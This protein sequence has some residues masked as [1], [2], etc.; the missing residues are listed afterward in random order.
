MKKNVMATVPN[1]MKFILT[2]VL[3]ILLI[4]GLLPV[5]LTL[6]AKADDIVGEYTYAE[7]SV[8][9]VNGT[10]GT[11]QADIKRNE[12]GKYTY[13]GQEYVFKAVRNISAG[14]TM[15]VNGANITL[16]ARADDAITDNLSD[17]VN[18]ANE[19][20]I[21]TLT[22]KP[23]TWLEANTPYVYS[24]NGNSYSFT[25]DQGLGYKAPDE[26]D[27]TERTD[28]TNAKAFSQNNDGTAPAT[29]TIDTAKNTIRI[30][31]KQYTRKV[32]Y[33]ETNNFTTGNV[34]LVGAKTSAGQNNM[35]IMTLN[36]GIQYTISRDTGY[37]DSACVHNKTDETV[38]SYA[39]VNQWNAYH[40]TMDNSLVQFSGR[41]AS[42]Y[43][44][45]NG[46]AAAI[47]TN[48]FNYYFE[49]ETDDQWVNSELKTKYESN[50]FS[51]GNLLMAYDATTGTYTQDRVF[52]SINSSDPTYQSKLNF[53]KDCFGKAVVLIDHNN[54]NLWNYTTQGSTTGNKYGY[55]SNGNTLST[56]ITQLAGGNPNLYYGGSN[57]PATSED[58]TPM[59]GSRNNSSPIYL[60]EKKTVYHQDV[61][62]RTEI[63]K[64]ESSAV[65][66]TMVG[67]ALRDV[68]TTLDYEGAKVT[69]GT[70]DEQNT[71][72]N[73][74]FTVAY[75]LMDFDGLPVT[76]T[77]AL[78]GLSENGTETET[79]KCEDGIFTSNI[80]MRDA[81][82]IT[83][84]DGL[85][86]GFVLTPTIVGVTDRS[87]ADRGN[88]TF[89][90]GPNGVGTYDGDYVANGSAVTISADLGKNV[91]LDVRD[92][93]REVDIRLSY[94]AKGTTQN[95]DFTIKLY[96][97]APNGQP[98]N[99]ELKDLQG[100]TYAFE[101]GVCDKRNVTSD[102]TIH[103]GQV[104]T[105]TGV[106]NGSA[107]YADVIGG[108][109]EYDKL[110][111]VSS[112]NISLSE[113]NKLL[114]DEDKETTTNK[115]IQLQVEIQKM[116]MKITFNTKDLEQLQSDYGAGAYIE[117][118]Q[119]SDN[120]LLRKVYIADGKANGTMAKSKEVVIVIPEVESTEDLYIK[121]YPR[122]VGS[123]TGEYAKIF[124]NNDSI[125][126]VYSNGNAQTTIYSP[127]SGYTNPDSVFNNDYDSSKKI[128]TYSQT[129]KY[130][131]SKD[132]S[133]TNSSGI[134][135]WNKPAQ[136]FQYTLPHQKNNTVTLAYS[137][138]N[139]LYKI[140]VMQRVVH[141][142][143]E[144]RFPVS[145]RLWN[146][147][148]PGSLNEPYDYFGSL[149]VY[150]FDNSNIDEDETTVARAYAASASLV[151]ATTSFKMYS[152]AAKA[153]RTDLGL[154]GEED[155]YINLPNTTTYPGRIQDIDVRA[156]G[157]F[158]YNKDKKIVSG[159]YITKY[160]ISDS[161]SSSKLD[162]PLKS[163]S[164][165]NLN[166]DGRYRIVLPTSQNQTI[167]VF[168]DIIPQEVKVTLETDSETVKNNADKK[169]LF[170]VKVVL[171]RDTGEYA[172]GESYQVLTQSIQECDNQPQNFLVNGEETTFNGRDGAEFKLADG[173]SIY[174]QLPWGY[175]AEV[176]STDG[177][178]N[179]TTAYET[180]EEAYAAAGKD[181]KY[182][183]TP[184]NANSVVAAETDYDIAKDD[185]NI[186][187]TLASN[188]RVTDQEIKVIKTRN[189][190]PDDIGLF[191][192]KANKAFLA[193]VA[194]LSLT[195]AG[196]YI[197]TKRK[198]TA[199]DG[200]E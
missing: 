107:L 69:N 113:T 130:I 126:A 124:V 127:R 80:L 76:G 191:G 119:Q 13:D 197:Y 52:G 34:F 47:G 36:Y 141:G 46:S 5:G 147:S 142:N 186:A 198:E 182:T 19:G 103:N 148:S 71:L 91:R 41:G 106:Q 144:K 16:E 32:I 108:M 183:V 184:Q 56:S 167:Y 27:G 74:Y 181:Y 168:R 117:V 149:G 79:V 122:V 158:D 60:F 173:Q 151:Q 8:I 65:G 6:F 50:T 58:N 187:V 86:E 61:I 98:F 87:D 55:M 10:T 188:T 178:V 30:Q 121:V 155:F 139:D 133:L 115:N 35:N 85:P 145:M 192:G 44:T 15:T 185:D 123:G 190:V 189:A 128:Y 82:F 96:M 33:H 66:L 171:Y 163:A 194:M 95:K 88:Y 153:S 152:V 64:P 51:S 81:D 17:L 31:G 164:L 57:S 135:V 84:A 11:A 20:G 162:A 2:A 54:G 49:A 9:T 179:Y 169:R 12:F 159:G 111:R 90:Q 7:L 93:K 3:A 172:D 21:Y 161:Y 99:G 137:T 116:D 110:A 157:A 23:D 53:H 138:T 40:R 48:G 125:G 196:A 59:T 97:N 70:T 1:K 176:T 62:D 78:T 199:Q 140:T 175:R 129:S 134:T 63:A 43:N 26:D 72:K 29:I 132:V 75:T 42:P 73:K 38:Y 104:I 136:Q 154:V 180:R 156:D 14:E 92:P 24:I 89:M 94:N 22:L 39:M 131:I 120:A 68:K 174:L 101:N 109:E 150:D 118:Y 170:N 102:I 166:E 195:A 200:L 28:S 18:V 67:H 77:F 100:N 83:F 177:Q 4:A 114:I 143:S 165:K 45:E 193:F 105:L 160:S 37:S 25:L 146:N 112:N